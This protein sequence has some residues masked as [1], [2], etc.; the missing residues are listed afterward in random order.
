VGGAAVDEAE[1]L[2]DIRV[3]G[4]GV[5]DGEPDRSL[6]PTVGGAVA[7][8]HDLRV[9]AHEAADDSREDAGELLAVAHGRDVGA[10]A[11]AVRI[12]VGE[13]HHIARSK[14]DARAVLELRPGLASE[15]EVVDDDVAI[16]A[17]EGARACDSGARKAHG[18]ENSAFSKR[19]L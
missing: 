17:G 15:D 2:A 6:E 12:A 16:G 11:N 13:A 10:V 7:D 18:A 19:R 1:S 3:A 9:A 5:R 8:V 4:A 14:R